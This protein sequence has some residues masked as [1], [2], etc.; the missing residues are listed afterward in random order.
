MNDQEPLAESF[1]S[2]EET[3]A[4]DE[5]CAP[6]LQ[7]SRPQPAPAN[8]RASVT[9]E[10]KRS[11]RPDLWAWLLYAAIIGG[12]G[13]VYYYNVSGIGR[14]VLSLLGDHRSL[15]LAIYPSVLWVVMGILLV[16]FRTVLWMFYRPFPAADVATAPLL[17][18]VI[19]A[20]NEGAMVLTSI[21]SVAEANYPRDRLEIV[22]V[23]DG[24][25]DDTWRYIA[26][27]AAAYPELV[28]ALRQDRNRGKRAALALGFERARGEVLV[29]LDSD[30]V[31]ERDALLAIAG[32]F[33]DP[34]VG[35]VAGK[36]LVYN[37]R[38]LIPRMLHVRFILSF[39]LLRS[40]ESAYRN[41]FC[42]PG[43]LTGLR[44]S[45]VKSV[46][47]RWR[48]QRFLGRECT[49]GEDRALTN[50]LL[51]EGYDTVYQRS[52]VVRTVVPQV[53][54]KLCKM[55]IRWDRSYVREEI[56]FARIVWKRPL[57]TRLIALYDRFVT[58]L[59][60][61]VQYFS[62][63]LL[64]DVAGHDP[65]VLARMLAGTALVS[66]VNMFYYLRSE[67]SFDFFYGV[68]YTYFYLF[69]LFW[70][71]PYALLT[72]RARSWLTR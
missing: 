15:A 57:P 25:R 67:R 29:T 23:D 52:A 31:I 1:L 50:F 61:P 16:I 19:P 40:V 41:V 47:A 8:D 17:T 26:E 63:F 58:N 11:D 5:S 60:F 43:A 56:R 72:V 28:T 42:C 30:S 48:H 7:Q 49:F 6:S 21:R 38:G 24:S 66:L 34:R 14:R 36:V 62:L 51:E 18:V 33:R 45:A 65:R 70:I 39:D 44:A 37:R 68:F 55:F 64:L 9:P 69:T 4:D 20:Y 35:A 27:A 59:R 71:F 53:Y 54:S 2:R 12:L 46:L 10:S 13:L 32:P 22:V 3:G